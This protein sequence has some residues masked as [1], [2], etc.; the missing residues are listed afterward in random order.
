MYTSMILKEKNLGLWIQ[1]GG[2]KAVSKPEGTGFYAQPHKEEKGRKKKKT[3]ALLVS[4][5]Q[6]EQVL[7]RG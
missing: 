4:H 7:Q 2:G 5:P 3:T 1:F 6:I